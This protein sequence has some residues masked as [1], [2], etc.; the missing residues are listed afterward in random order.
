MRKISSREFQKSFAEITGSLKNGQVVEITR[1]GKT[2]GKFTKTNGKKIKMPDF[3][4]E[5]QKHTYSME[6][7]E[8]WLKEFNDSLGKQ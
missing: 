3:W 1:H 6:M 4:A 5:V 2:I 7:G 8:K